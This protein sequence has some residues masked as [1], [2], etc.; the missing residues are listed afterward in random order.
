M[1]WLIKT[2]TSSV[3]KKFTM[4][5]TG[6]FLISFLIVHASINA[7]IFYNDGGEIFTI[8]A[9][10]MATNLI[11]R[12]IEIVL[13]VGLLLHIIQALLLWRSNRAAR[14]IRY[15]VIK[16]PP[17]STW[18]SRSMTLLGTLI[19]LFLVIHTSNF[20]IPNRTHQ[21]LYG[22]ELPLYDMMIEKFSDPI[23]VVIYL[24]G[25]FS[26][27]WHL[28]HGFAS[29]FQSLGLDHNKYK[30]LIRFTGKAFSVIICLTFAMMP[31]S[32]YL[33]WIR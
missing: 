25:A 31:I 1:N 8:G 9:H 18:Y 28:L 29:A 26:L 30:G 19:L 13:V 12:T 22:E 7:L 33:K 15:A 4:A 3:G 2:L 14:P 21:F 20:W 11:I 6:L 27:F 5:F 10:F 32:I 16:H 24:L 17:Q 23:E